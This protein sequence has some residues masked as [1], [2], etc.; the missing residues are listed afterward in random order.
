[1]LTNKF[2]SKYSIKDLLESLQRNKKSAAIITLAGFMLSACQVDQ[3]DTAT[4]TEVENP[5]AEIKINDA[6]EER[7]LLWGDTHVHS[8]LSFDA[9]S[10]GCAGC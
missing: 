7:Q 3:P 1:M 9:F 2:L 8:N 6:Y 10:F 4:T 5:A